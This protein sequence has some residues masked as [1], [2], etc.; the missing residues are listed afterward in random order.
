MSRLP[1]IYTNFRNKS[2]GQLAFF[3]FF[4]GFAGSAA[5]LATVLVETDDFLYRLQYIIGTALNGMLVAQFL[6]YWNSGAKEQP[7][8]KAVSDGKK[9]KE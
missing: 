9:K 8:G 6:L 7:K 5:R 4:L 3:T 2:T 1:Q